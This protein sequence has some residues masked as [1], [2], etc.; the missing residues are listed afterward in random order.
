MRLSVI[1]SSFLVLG[2]AFSSC[3]KELIPDQFKMGYRSG[4]SVKSLQ[5]EVLFSG[6]G[7]EVAKEIDLDEDG[8]YDLKFYT[9]ATDSL[10]DQDKRGSSVWA[11]DWNIEF[12]YQVAY[13]DLYSV[14]QNSDRG[15]R[16]IIFNERS[17]F[18]CE[19]CQNLSQKSER[20]T[21]ST[22]V[23]LEEGNS[24]SRHIKWSDKLQ[25]LSQFDKSRQYN[26]ERNDIPV[27][28]NIMTGIW[29]ENGEGYLPFRIKTSFAKYQYG[30]IK[31]RV[32]DH[33]RIEFF[34][35]AIQED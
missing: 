4:V 33:R 7:Q 6:Y 30:W 21:F 28:N 15:L 12:G 5:N 19:S 9:Y 17:H 24:L 35:I 13:D 26:R 2:I 16:E 29:D 20:F 1:I 11:L 34:E 27:Y 18:N 3:Q 22:P 14:T 23:L 8:E 25:I 32:F 31:L 10:G